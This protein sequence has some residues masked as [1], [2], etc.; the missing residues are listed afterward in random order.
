V[1]RQLLGLDELTHYDRYAPL[2][3]EKSE[4]SFPE[5]QR[6]VLESFRAFSPRVHA[7]A[8]PFFSRSWIDAEL[9]PG[10]RGGAFCSSITPDLHPYVFMNYTVK[11]RDVMT[12]AHELGHGLHQYLSRPVG[13]LQCDTPLTTAE[14]ASVF[15][16]MLTFQRLLQ[17]Y[18]EPRTRLA[19]L[20]SKIEDGFATVFRQVVLTRFEQSLHRARKEQGE[21]TTEQINELWLAANRPMHG[22]VVRLTIFRN[23]ELRTVD[24]KRGRRE[25]DYTI[26]PVEKPDES[27]IIERLMIG[28]ITTDPGA[29]YY[30]RP[31][32]RRNTVRAVRN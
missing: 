32:S 13:Y 25:P 7:A 20:C 23:D 8:E 24:I 27:Q 19:M 14:M 31:R 5:A 11:P 22:D 10:K 1:K 30:A 16:E 26:V 9:R 18:P 17:L 12:L 4:I 28:S 29:P 15:G 3:L 2:L 6:L 21:L